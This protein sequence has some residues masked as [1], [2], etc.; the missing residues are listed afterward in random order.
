MAAA[1]VSLGA[2]ATLGVGSAAATTLC[3]VEGVN[4]ECPAGKEW[5]NGT[6]VKLVQQGESTFAIGIATV[7][8][9]TSLLE[10][11]TTTQ[12]GAGAATW[13]KLTLTNRSFGGCNCTTTALRPSWNGGIEGTGNRDGELG[14]DNEIKFEC[15]MLLGECIYETEVITIVP[16]KGGE[17]AL[18]EIM[19]EP[20]SLRS[21]AKGCAKPGKW[22]AIYEFAT[23][24]PMY[25]TES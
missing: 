22:T 20:L 15:G 23:P 7:K 1:L 8:C 19:G 14:F 18:L 10:G 2:L 25:V 13:V 4:E 16:V 11:K 17:P 3:S 9:K 21:G 6:N 12:G 24:S 5:G